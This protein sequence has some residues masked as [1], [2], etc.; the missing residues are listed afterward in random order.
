MG[1]VFRP[2]W[3]L[4]PQEDKIDGGDLSHS[5]GFWPRNDS[6]HSRVYVGGH[7]VKKRPA[8]PR[9]RWAWNPCQWRD[10]T[11][12]QKVKE[13]G[14]RYIPW[15]SCRVQPCILIPVFVARA[16]AITLFRPKK[17]R[18][19]LSMAD[20]AYIRGRLQKRVSGTHPFYSARNAFQMTVAHSTISR[21]AIGISMLIP[22]LVST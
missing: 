11:G 8:C 19:V 17:R 4:V 13:R 2:R 16:S 12:F 3:S 10:G 22:L 18:P 21:I 7:E 15:R 20:R 9:R 5:R 14:T 6:N 1:T